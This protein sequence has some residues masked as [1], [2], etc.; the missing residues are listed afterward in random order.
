VTVIDLIIEETQKRVEQLQDDLGSGVAKDYAEYR[1]ICGVV[2]GMLAV[3]RYVD[4]IKTNL[5][6]D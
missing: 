1:Y 3:K 4:D 6:N 2:N 5:E